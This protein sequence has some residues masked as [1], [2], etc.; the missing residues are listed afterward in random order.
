[1]AAELL[2]EGGAVERFL[3]LSLVRNGQTLNP[4]MMAADEEIIEADVIE[5]VIAGGLVGVSSTGLSSA[6]LG[7]LGNARD[8]APTSIEGAKQRFQRPALLSI[9]PPAF[10]S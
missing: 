9:V 2:V 8:N 1:L 6:A 3:E 4:E 10:Q 5:I 7:E